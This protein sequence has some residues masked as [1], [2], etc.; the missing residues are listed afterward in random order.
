MARQHYTDKDYEAA[1]QGIMRAYPYHLRCCGKVCESNAICGS[2]GHKNVRVSEEKMES[3]LFDMY[4]MAKIHERARYDKKIAEAKRKAGVNNEMLLTIVFDQSDGSHEDQLHAIHAQ[5]A[6]IESIKCANYKWLRDLPVCYSYEYYTSDL[7]RF[8]P[9]LHFA[10][11]KTCAPSTIQQILYNK[12][13]KKKL[14]GV[15][16]VNCVMRP[17]KVAFDYVMG[18]KRDDKQESCEK[19]NIFREKYD[20]K[21]YYEF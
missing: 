10:F 21:K 17:N 18:K 20:L 13:V 6:V 7:S 9:H 5:N 4:H 2:C 12:F 11:E 8:K 15:Y 16:G 14:H 3:Q 1:L 19:D